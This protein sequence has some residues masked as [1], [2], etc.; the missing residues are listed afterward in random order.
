MLGIKMRELLRPQ[1]MQEMQTIVIDDPVVWCVCQSVC[2]ANAKTT[3]WLEILFAALILSLRDEWLKILPIIVQ[4]TN[5]AF[6]THSP[7][8]ATCNAASANSLL[9]LFDSCCTTCHNH[10]PFIIT[11]SQQRKHTI[12]NIIHTCMVRPCAWQNQGIR[13]Q[14]SHMN[15]VSWS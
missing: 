7:D 6:L 2:H 14:T 15:N 4:Y 8:G 11:H 1:R 5:T 9:L 3:E 12:Y 13:H 10:I